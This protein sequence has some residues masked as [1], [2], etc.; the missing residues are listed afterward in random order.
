MSSVKQHEYG[1]ASS[2]LGTMRLTGQTISM[3]I[4]MMIFALMM[5]ETE[6][7]ISNTDGLLSGIKISFLVFA[8]LCIAGVFFS[9]KRGKM[10]S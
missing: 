9:M 10:R 7:S 3:G 8:L 4:S 6:K 2:L 1:V 5:G